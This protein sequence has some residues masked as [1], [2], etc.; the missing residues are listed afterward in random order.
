MHFT[1]VKILMCSNEMSKRV[2]P[3]WASCFHIHVRHP[4]GNSQKYSAIW[5][6]DQSWIFDETGH[7]PHQIRGGIVSSVGGGSGGIIS[8]SIRARWSHCLLKHFTSHLGN[9]FYIPV[10]GL[11]DFAIDMWPVPY[12]G[13]KSYVFL[14]FAMVGYVWFSFV[15]FNEKELR[16]SGSF[17]NINVNWDIFKYIYIACKGGVISLSLEGSSN[18]GKKIKLKIFN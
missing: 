1:S 15:P 10:L 17:N 6:Q 9:H 11:F 8:A 4:Q 7:V 2:P 16:L 12:N 18:C 3:L 5:R 14:V 13:P